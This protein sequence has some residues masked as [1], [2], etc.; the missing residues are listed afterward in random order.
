VLTRF[1]ED[2]PFCKSSDESFSLIV[3]KVER[4]RR[5]TEFD[6]ALGYCNQSAVETV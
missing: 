3:R 2:D 5:K 6:I 1:S 4:Q